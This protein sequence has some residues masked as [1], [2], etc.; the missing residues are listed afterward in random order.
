M[1]GKPLGND[2]PLVVETDGTSS[3]ALKFIN[4]QTGIDGNV[5][6]DT[7]STSD[8]PLALDYLTYNPAIVSITH[9]LTTIGMSATHEASIGESQLVRVSPE[10]QTAIATITHSVKIISPQTVHI[11]GPNGA[12]DQVTAIL[13]GSSQTDNIPF[14]VLMKNGS[15]VDAAHLAFKLKD[16]GVAT[17]EKTSCDLE[18]NPDTGEGKCEAIQIS[19]QQVGQSTIVFDSDNSWWTSTLDPTRH[20]K[21]GADKIVSA[22]LNIGTLYVASDDNKLKRKWTETGAA[23]QVSLGTDRSIFPGSFVLDSISHKLYSFIDGNKLN[24]VDL[25]KQEFNATTTNLWTNQVEQAQTLLPTNKSGTL[26]VGTD[27]AHAYLV[28]DLDK[29][30]ATKVNTNAGFH[31][32]VDTSALDVTSNFDY[33]MD[34]TNLKYYDLS[35]SAWVAIADTHTNP[36]FNYLVSRQLAVGSQL[37]Y[38][39]GLKANDDGSYSSKLYNI[40]EG[41]ATEVEI[42]GDNPFNENNQAILVA[43]PINSNFYAIGSSDGKI[44]QLDVSDNK[45]SFKRVAEISGATDIGVMDV[46]F[47][48]NENLYLGVYAEGK[49]HNSKVYKVAAANHQVTELTDYAAPAGK[50]ITS[51]IVDNHQ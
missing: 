26:L 9:P 11:E 1:D 35:K 41:K 27:A 15:G 39:L 38:L 51:L 4:V 6:L 46:A 49:D 30:T 7:I 31:S 18:F 8:D 37:I 17:L 42:T 29:P 40:V 36:D 13:T 2:I 19:P 32:V 34:S 45:A 47:D 22:K 20:Q 5:L 28:S 43:S 14:T 3:F 16:A 25:M 12:L 24:T 23:E 10:G 44:Y 50:H 33:F 48:V 21:F